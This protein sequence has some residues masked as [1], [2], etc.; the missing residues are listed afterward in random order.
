MESLG[1]THIVRM[2]NI[3]Q[4]RLAIG[5]SQYFTDPLQEN[6]RKKYLKLLYRDGGYVVFEISQPG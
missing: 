3:P 2:I 6:F 1:I 5:Y 4:S